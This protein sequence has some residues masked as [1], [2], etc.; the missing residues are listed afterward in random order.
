MKKFFIGL[1]FLIIIILVVVFVL[2]FTSFGNNILKPHIQSQID[3][4][5][6][7][8]ISLDVFNL[9]WGSF[10]L[11]L[12]SQSNIN[13]TSNGT[14]SLIG[15]DID[16]ILNI[17][18]A[19]P[20]NIK[21]LATAGVNLQNDFLIENVIRGKF[22]NIEIDTKS[23][24]ANGNLR[25]VTTIANFK[26]T[27]IIADLEKLQVDELLAVVG[28]KP[29]VS[30]EINANANIVGDENLQFTGQALAK[31]SSGTVSTNLVKQDFNI[32]V[33]STTFTVNLLANFDGTNIIHK[34]EFLS[35]IGNI[36]SNGNTIIKT[37]K[38]NSTYDVD[39][40]DLSPFTP[41]VGMP[42]RGSFRTD[43]KI[44]G[45]AKWMNVEG[46]SDFAASNTMYSVSFE[47]YTKP[48]D[49]LITIK[50][51]RIEDVLYMLVKPIYSKGLLNANL[52]FKGISSAINGNYS[53]TLNGNIQKNVIKNEFD[54]NLNNNLSYT[55]KANATFSNGNGLI[56]ADILTELANLNVKNAVLNISNLSLNAPYTLDVLDLKKLAFITPKE[57]KGSIHA[58]GEIKWTPT[59]LYADLKSDIFGGNLD[60]HLNNNIASIMIKNMNSTGILDMLQY[61]QFFKSNIN[62][63]IQYDTQTQQGKM[64]MILN[65]GSFT[66]NK[67]TNLIQNLLKFDTTKEVYNNIKIDGTIDKK[68]I[69]ADLNMLSNNTSVT[70]KD[71]KIDIENDN[72]N[73]NLVLK[74]QNYELGA[75]VSGK[76]A[77]PNIKLDTKKLGQDILKNLK[78]NKKVQEQKEK[79][80]TKIE[81]QKQQLQDKAKDAL[82]KGLDKLFNK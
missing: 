26:P 63:D 72:I 79:I 58:N 3:K 71:A 73:A 75:I 78:S 25:I 10:T 24:I 42:L 77:N 70:S 52:D 39:I 47:Q 37:L 28:K 9:R 4:Y 16:A 50:N 36:N 46:K 38:T 23:N 20:S 31:I 45:N 68:L 14:F 51:L 17:K 61:P 19:N 29:Y 43:G 59:S 18:I 12:N 44:I 49:A 74:V 64:E 82:Q 55:H 54:I 62:G 2:L 60:A 6:P 67:L 65:Q 11:E 81:E 8:P 35:N 33:P 32:A 21:E 40:A 57:L 27:K 34:L 13:I 5:S 30:G 66:E 22:T 80:E 15:Q 1:L 7:I 69:T 41:F 76:I 53:H 48:K 56:N